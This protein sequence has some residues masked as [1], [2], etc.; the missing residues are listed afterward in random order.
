MTDPTPFRILVTGSRGWRDE[1]HQQLLIDSIVKSVHWWISGHPENDTV[2]DWVTV[3]H[4]DC[5]DGADAM[6]DWF[7]RDVCNWTV[8]K[9]PAQW[10]REDGSENRAAGFER[11]SHMVG[12]GADVCLCFVTPCNKFS[13]QDQPPHPSHGAQHCA[14]LAVAA[15]IKTITTYDNGYQKEG[16]P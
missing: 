16:A 8:E 1:S 10:E 2:T 5:P 11:N 14:W 6:A 4:G 13:H 3:V 12:L 9:H 7:A 15:G